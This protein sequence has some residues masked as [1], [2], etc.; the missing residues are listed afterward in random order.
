MPRYPNVSETPDKF[1][2]DGNKLCRNCN[3]IVAEGRRH[4][5]SEGCM[6]EFN[7][8]NSWFWIRKDVLKRD[9][10]TCSICKTRLRK[11]YLD[12]DHIIPVRLGGNPFNK[13]NL[14]TLCKECHKAKTKL[15][16]EALED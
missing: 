16:K 10:Y 12:V 6:D 7:R 13:D 2:A 3:N 14:R 1:D 15:D 8:N 4:Y 9:R 11:R 5:C